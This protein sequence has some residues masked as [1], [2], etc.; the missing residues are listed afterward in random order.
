MLA[1]LHLTVP[2]LCLTPSPAC[3][4]QQSYDMNSHGSVHG[5]DV[6]VDSCGVVHVNSGGAVVHRNSCNSHGADVRGR[7]KPLSMSTRCMHRRPAVGEL[8]WGRVGC[9][10]LTISQEVDIETVCAVTVSYH[11]SPFFAPA[12]PGP[13]REVRSWIGW[14]RPGKTERSGVWLPRGGLQGEW[15]FSTLCSWGL[16]RE[17]IVPNSVVGP[18]AFLVLLLILVRH[19]CRATNW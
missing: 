7:S 17:R 4:L 1:C 5:C 6:H 19:S 15:V 12:S 16:G 3:H 10:T 13:G 2:T 9:L 8:A 18:L 11:P 14:T